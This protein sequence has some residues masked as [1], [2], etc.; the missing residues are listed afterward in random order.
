M[1]LETIIAKEEINMALYVYKQTFNMNEK[2]YLKRI[3]SKKFWES[4]ES[5]N[6]WRRHRKLTA[7]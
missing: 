1:K 4:F 3:R 6:L 7:K 5:K 2:N